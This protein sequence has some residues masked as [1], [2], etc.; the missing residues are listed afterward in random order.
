MALSLTL[1][2]FSKRQNSTAVPATSGT[3]V[4]VTLK[5]ETS[6]NNP[7]FLLSGQRPD[8]TYALFDG[9]Y[10][11]ID[12][13]R[14]V[15]NNL[16]EIVCSIDPLGTYR[17]EIG[18]T[19]AF[20]EYATQGD[21]NIMD[22]R[23][24][25]E[26]PASAIGATADIGIREDGGYILSTVGKDGAKNWIVSEATLRS[27]LASVDTWMENVI[28]TS[29]SQTEAVVKL[30]QQMISSGS[31]MDCIRSCHYIPFQF[32]EGI[33]GG[34]VTLG[35]FE[36]AVPAF[37]ITSMIEKKTVD[38]SIPY[39]R[40]GWLRLEPYTELYLYLPFV[41]CVPIKTARKTS[42]TTLHI[43]VS[44]NRISGD[45][46]YDVL[47]GGQ[48]VGN[49]GASTAVAVPVGSSNIPPAR[50]LNAI[51]GGLG[52]AAATAATGNPLGAMAA[53]MS[54]LQATEPQITSVGGIQGGAGA[55]LPKDISY[56][57]IEHPI[58]AAPGN[59]AATQG[60]PLFAQRSLGSLTGYI[61]TRGASVTGS[62]RGSI[63]DRLNAL[64]DAGFFRE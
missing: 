40:S 48:H 6:L 21:P 22:S 30:G 53:G 23:I 7:I 36:T 25:A 19:S 31:A 27:I 11:F 38:F 14:S 43:N 2:S 39:S 61:K 46:A 50:L 35:N 54:I 8:A 58:N 29:A 24:I 63:R 62:I 3:V 15:R 49:Y 26:S 47:Y 59:M 9:A 34:L 16:Y 56:V 57:L 60:I 20:V 45:I 41:G 17:T 44:I 42:V 32:T 37:Y 64:L 55:G 52:G 13:I 51:L 33:G 18:N 4:E 5:N 12:D 28:P 10:Y 1:F